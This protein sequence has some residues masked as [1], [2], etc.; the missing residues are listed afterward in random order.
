MAIARKAHHHDRGLPP[1][2]GQPGG[3][4]QLYP[5]L[6]SISVVPALL[7]ENARFES[8]CIDPAHGKHVEP[9]G[10]REAIA[11]LAAE[12][13]N[14]VP[15]PCTR[16]EAGNPYIDFYDGKGRPY[17]VKTPPSPRPT[18]RWPFNPAQAGAAILDD[19]ESVNANKLT[20]RVQPVRI[21]LDVTYLSRADHKALWQYLKDNGK[22]EAL[23]RIV[24]VSAHR[25]LVHVRNRPAPPKKIKKLRKSKGRHKGQTA[26]LKPPPRGSG[27]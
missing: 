7:A 25:D 24:E 11:I 21:L 19:L 16:P 4:M 8:L 18:D 12:R 14:L 23:N 17:D 13:Q 1:R 5:R 10:I 9:G 6:R 27:R 26:A 22:P 15:G 3:M 20:K 2:V